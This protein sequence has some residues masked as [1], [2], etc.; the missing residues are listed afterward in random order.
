MTPSILT[1]NI[2]PGDWQF[3]LRGVYRGATKTTDE[4]QFFFRWDY[5]DEVLKKNMPHP[6]RLCR[7]VRGPDSESF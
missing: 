4:T 5:L 1:G 2:Y 6:K 7:L 3:V